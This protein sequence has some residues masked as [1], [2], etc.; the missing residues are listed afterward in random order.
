MLKH[1]VII[2]ITAIFVWVPTNCKSKMAIRFCVL[3]YT[4]PQYIWHIS[5]VQ[6]TRY[7]Y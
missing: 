5:S 3:I 4:A 2:Q 7:D 1:N 6:L